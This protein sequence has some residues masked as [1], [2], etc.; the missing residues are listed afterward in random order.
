[1]EKI[2]HIGEGLLYAQYPYL[3]CKLSSM[4]IVRSRYHTGLIL[5]YVN[6]YYLSWLVPTV[7]YF[8]LFDH[9]QVPLKQT[10][11]TVPVSMHTI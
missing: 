5:C 9:E 11:L 3:L 8:V 10:S 4:N 2:V 7:P 1:M 6:F